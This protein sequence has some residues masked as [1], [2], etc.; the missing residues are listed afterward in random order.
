MYVRCNIFVS[1][2]S[3]FIAKMMIFFDVMHNYSVVYCCFPEK[4]LPLHPYCNKNDK[5][6]KTGI[7][8]EII[9]DVP[10]IY[11]F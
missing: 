4:I 10:K 3:I 7:N 6:M 11:R 8:L 1:I 9:P 2:M 5:E